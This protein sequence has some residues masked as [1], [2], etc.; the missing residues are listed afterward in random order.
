MDD[1]N[2]I[3]QE[4]QD[5]N[6]PVFETVPVDENLR[7]EEVPANVT[8]TEEAVDSLSNTGDNIPEAPPIIYEDNKAKYLLIAG[9]LIFFAVF[10]FLIVKLISGGVKKAS[11]PVKLVYW[12]LWEE[13]DVYESLISQYQAKNKV[14]IDYQKMSPQEYLQKLITRSKNGQGPDIFR[15]HNTWLPQLK[16]VLSPLASSVMTNT[17]FESTFYPIHQRDLKVGNYYFG[18]PLTIDGLVL[19]CNENLFKKAGITSYP[20]NWNEVIDDAS[21]LSVKDLNGNL[22]TAGIALGLV[23]NVEHFSDDFG[24]I[25]LQN[26]GSLKQLDQDTAAGALESYRKFAEDPKNNFWDESMPNSLTAFIQEKVA[27]ILVPSWEILTIKAANPDIKIKV[28]TT[29][30]VPGGKPLSLASYWVEGVSRYSKNQIESWKFIKYLT[31]K[32]NMVKLYENE[33][34]TR[35]FG[36]PYSRVDLASTIV[37]NEY[38]GSVIQQAKYYVSLPLISR[39]Y[40]SGLNDEIIRYLENAINATVQGVSYNEALKTAK[41]GIDQIIIRYKIE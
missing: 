12:G 27:M 22:I 4:N 20:T 2:V 31:E 17:E 35:L 14:I 32:E 38:I 36:E 24:L 18:L 8:T 6:Q 1:D 10:F 26:G 9:G 25:L 28:M 34:K 5:S 13:K 15:F 21:K 30:I 19:V 37:Q 3:N 11:A 29:P 39:T 33:S 16:E 23:S 41:Q 40:D 7:P